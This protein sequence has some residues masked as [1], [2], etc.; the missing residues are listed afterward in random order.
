VGTF[1][2]TLA[3]PSNSLCFQMRNEFTEETFF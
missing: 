3:L 1:N 2:R